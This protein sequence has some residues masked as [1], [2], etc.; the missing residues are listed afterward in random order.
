M[1]SRERGGED[2]MR[3]VGAAWWAMGSAAAMIAWAPA[4]WAT[5]LLVGALMGPRGDAAGGKAGGTDR[6]PE[7]AVL[8]AAA[9][10]ATPGAAQGATKAAS[11]VIPLTGAT[12]RKAGAAGQRRAPTRP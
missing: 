9:R 2:W 3:S 7:T 11:N 1:G 6:G 10:V 8:Q 12:A 4:L 5:P